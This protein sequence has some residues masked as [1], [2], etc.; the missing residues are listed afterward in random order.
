VVDISQFI[1]RSTDPPSIR[2]AALATATIGGV[3]LAMYQ[4]LIN[5][6]VA[7]GDGLARL[8]TAVGTG[9]ANVLSLV[10]TSPAVAAATGWR[11]LR[12]FVVSTGPIGLIVGTASVLLVIYILVRGVSAA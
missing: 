3:L 12:E 11:E 6:V 2:W 4:G 9:T 5:F 7:W 8:L 10:L 1:N